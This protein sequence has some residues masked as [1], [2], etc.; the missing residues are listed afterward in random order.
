M[1]VPITVCF[2]D[3]LDTSYSVE[4][5]VGVTL[6]ENTKFHARQ[7][8]APLKSDDTNDEKALLSHIEKHLFE[9]GCPG[10]PLAELDMGS[11]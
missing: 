4:V 8:A 7:I 1:V 5:G 9:M 11:A 3:Q 10:R 6:D 2:W